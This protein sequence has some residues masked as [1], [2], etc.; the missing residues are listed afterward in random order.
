MLVAFNTFDGYN[1]EDAIVISERLVK[2]DAFTS[3][4]STRSTWRSARQA[5]AE[6]VHSRHPQRL[7]K[8]L[9]NLDDNGIIRLGAAAPAILVG[10]VSP[11]SKTS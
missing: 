7:R 10:K 8:M 1:F 2:N 4:P 3:I 11:K 9:R 5:G 6:G